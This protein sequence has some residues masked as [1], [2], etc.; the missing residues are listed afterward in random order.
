MLF[1]LGLEKILAFAA[2]SNWAGLDGDDRK[3]NLTRPVET[4]SHSG[5]WLP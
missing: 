5:T 3:Y 2:G 4:D 1:V